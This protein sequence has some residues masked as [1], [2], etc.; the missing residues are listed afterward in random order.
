MSIIKGTVETFKKHIWNIWKDFSK[1]PDDTKDYVRQRI[2]RQPQTLS[3]YNIVIANKQRELKELL[4]TVVSFHNNQ[5]SDLK[6]GIAHRL[7]L[8]M[9]IKNFPLDTDKFDEIYA[10]LKEIDASNMTTEEKE[11][12][13]WDALKGLT[14]QDVLSLQVY[15]YNSNFW[16]THIKDWNKLRDLVLFQPHISRP[17]KPEWE[18]IKPKK[19][20]FSSID[21]YETALK[22]RQKET[23]QWKRTPEYR[24]R[25]WRTEKTEWMKDILKAV[26][27][28]WPLNRLSNWTIKNLNDFLERWVWAWVQH[29][30]ETAFKPNI[31]EMSPEEEEMLR[32]ILIDVKYGKKCFILLNHE[33]FAN[34]P[35]TIVKFMQ[36]AHELWIKNV[37][38]YFTTMVW[39]L[40]ATHKK[41]STMLNSL[42]SVLVTHPADN[43]V[44]WAKS[45]YSHQQR[46]ATSQIENDFD[47]GNPKWQI[48]FCAPS[49]TRDIVHYWEDWI[50][51]IYI[52]DSSWWS[53]MTTGRLIRYLHK[54]NPDIKFYAISTNTIGLKKP[55]EKKWVSPN[56]NK[57]NKHATVCLHLKELNSEDLSTENFI[58]TILNN[59]TYPI[60]P[61]QPIEKSKNPFKRNSKKKNSDYEDNEWI[62]EIPCGTAIPGNIFKFLKKFTKTPEYAVNWQLP[63]RFF[64]EEWKL[65]LKK[66]EDEM[67]KENS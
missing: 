40:I 45:I 39:P 35:I 31:L 1:L 15:N 52:P 61:E 32:H 42:S 26:L 64:D 18:P 63:S 5:L 3:S 44:P 14:S 4:D 9:D 30:I 33:T 46:N 10:R 38:E 60:P 59:I 53:N 2:L 67:L 58:S 66:V 34:I 20:D 56:N 22:Q 57:W 48:Y 29:T 41:Q 43:K 28:L 55:N 65:D 6:N 17:E 24:Q 16:N 27:D 11:A 62:K 25:S 13:Q 50:P 12:A 36:V 21:E 54:N 37:N 51:Q 49:W 23:R 47:S 8:T 7:F 19:S